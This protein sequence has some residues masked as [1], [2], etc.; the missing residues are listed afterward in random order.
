MALGLK[1]ICQLQ[2][3][4]FPNIILSL[5]TDTSTFSGDFWWRSSWGCNGSDVCRPERSLAGFSTLNRQSKVED[6]KMQKPCVQLFN[7]SIQVEDGGVNCI[8]VFA[9]YLLPA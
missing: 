7:N 3:Q 2:L 6:M 9:V 8:P 4:G 1:L 5:S